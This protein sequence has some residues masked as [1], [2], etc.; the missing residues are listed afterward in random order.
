MLLNPF[1]F[2]GGGGGG[3]AIAIGNHTKGRSAGT[4]LTCDAAISTPAGATLY[5]WVIW[6]AGQNISGSGTLTDVAGNALTL[7]G[8]EQNQGGSKKALYVCE[9]ALGHAAN[10][11][12]ATFGGASFGSIFF[13]AIV[14][15]AATSVDVNV[16]GEAGAA[17]AI[18]SGTLAQADELVLFCIGSD[19]GASTV[20]YS[21]TGGPTL[22]LIDSETDG[23]NYYTGAVF[24]KVVAST[25]STSMTLSTNGGG[26]HAGRVVSVR[27]A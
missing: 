9:N 17:L 15:A 16:A 18:A 19:S 14:N 7:R 21:E 8:T 1:R 25:A 11:I 6:E 13:G 5:S 12:T 20:T 10:N 23:V 26:T 22:T 2:G 3:G 4:S 27:Q 24:A